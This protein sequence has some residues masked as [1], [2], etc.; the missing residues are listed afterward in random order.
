MAPVAAHQNYGMIIEVSGAQPQR[1]NF[2]TIVMLYSFDEIA[3][4][5]RWVDSLDILVATVLITVVIQWIRN[6][7]AHALLLAGGGVAGLYFVS[8]W[9]R[10]YLAMAMFQWALPPVLIAL[11][12]MFQNDLRHGFEKL[13]S[14]RPFHRERGQLHQGSFTEPLVKAVLLLAEEKSGALIV[15]PARQNLERHLQGG[16]LLDGQIS[17][18]LLHSIFHSK[19]QG[20]DGA[21]VIKGK[22]IDRFGVHLPLSNNFAALGSGG[23][24]HAAAL[25]LS[26]LC[27]ALVI[28]VSEERGSISLSQN[29]QIHG[30]ADSN[31]LFERL[32]RFYHHGS[33]GKP[34][35]KALNQLAGTA[36]VV[37]TSFC[38]AA[39]L[40]FVFA[41]QV[42]SVQ[43]VVDRVPI[44]TR[45][46]P[47]D[48]V[49]ESIE[50]EKLRI[51]IAGSER[52][53]NAFSWDQLSA[54]LN[55]EE[56]K[57]GFQIKVV[58][59]DSLS[60]PPEMNIVEIEPNVIWVTA[61][62]TI[63]IEL[64][65]EITTQG[66]LP[67]GY[68]LESRTSSPAK[69]SVK[70]RKSRISEFTSIPTTPV[71]LGG[72]Q[73][74]FEQRVGLQ[75]PEGVWPSSKTPATVN[76]NLEIQPEKPEENDSSAANS[77]G[78]NQS[79]SAGSLSTE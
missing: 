41:Y 17:L 7:S 23:T 2:G 34:G 64:P 78:G 55:M 14:W 48:W 53:F 15:L 65:I 9:L 39:L 4:S 75:L 30:V 70:V 49:V 57:D 20:H 76:V 25:G 46:L 69:V 43:R 56:V 6:R 62:Q 28:V 66:A 60:L 29:G 74:S 3:R 79:D 16:V 38:T 13:A 31:Q 27:D 11:V 58:G 19:S 18:P 40:W 42:E 54:G 36:L 50:P 73:S 59:E 35:R 32:D 21:V 37:L 68:S 77:C 71:E 72:K 47:E 63:T 61:Y 1:A 5:F 10:M 22:R 26:E 33:R 51:N 12:V 45:N 52:A 8:Q 24:R 44:V 67:R